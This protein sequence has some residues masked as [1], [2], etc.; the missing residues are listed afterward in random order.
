[1][2][3]NGNARLSAKGRLLLRR[4]VIDGG[5]SLTPAAAASG[6]SELTAAKGFGPTLEGA[7]NPHTAALVR[8][9]DALLAP[10]AIGIDLSVSALCWG[11]GSM[12]GSVNATAR[13]W[14]AFETSR[15]AWTRRSRGG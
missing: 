14:V 7:L 4:R 10:K 12:A 9:G 11:F 13:G 15:P 3:L 1:M 2:K 6:V 5:W 8:L